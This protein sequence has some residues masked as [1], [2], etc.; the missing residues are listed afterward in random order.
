[1]NQ[2][3]YLGA[4][5]TLGLSRN[6]ALTARLLGVSQRQLS[7]YANGHCPIPGPV[8]RLIRVLALIVERSENAEAHQAFAAARGGRW[9][10]A[11][12]LLAGEKR[13][14]G[15]PEFRGDEKSER[16]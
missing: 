12:A 8:A 7:N 3:E 13:Y 15:S 2:A 11:A 16:A 5:A 14:K 6:S 1:M 4:L 9:A 10:A